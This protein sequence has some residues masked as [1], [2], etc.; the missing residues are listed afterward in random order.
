MSAQKY[1]KVCHDAGKTEAEYRSHFTR[2]NK[3]ANAKVVCP[4]LLSQEC[5]Y[6]FKNGHTVKYCPVLK[7]SNAVS[8]RPVTAK[9]APVLKKSCVPA[10]KNAFAILESDSESDVEDLKPVEV[11][12][13]EF[14]QLARPSVTPAVTT[15]NY[16]DVL[17]SAPVAKPCPLSLQLP[18]KTKAVASA[19][20]AFQVNEKINWAALDSESE[21]EEEE[22]WQQEA[23]YDSDW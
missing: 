8:S 17:K 22:Q 19:P 20:W 1:C 9:P 11:V 13:E 5:R 18:E 4:T 23:E 3:S 16:L 2:E 6:C 21:E 12:K 10:S 15:K 14:P 7:K